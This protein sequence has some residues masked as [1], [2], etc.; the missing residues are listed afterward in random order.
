MEQIGERIRTLRES[1]G[2]SQKEL[3]AR[4]VEISASYL[5][6]VENV[7]IKQP[8]AV[9]LRV[10]AKALEVTF[11]DLIKN[12][13][14]AVAATEEDRKTSHVWCVNRNCPKAEVDSEVANQPSDDPNVARVLVEIMDTSYI[15]QWQEDGCW[16]GIKRYPSF[17]AYNQVGEKNT[18]CPACGSPL[19]DKCP[20]CKRQI[21]SGDQ[22]FCMGCGTDIWRSWRKIM[23]N[24]DEQVRRENQAYIKGRADH[25]LLDSST[26]GLPRC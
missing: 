6:N 24:P 17:P 23:Q 15:E 9:K 12:T 13:D 2:L 18:F 1:K 25:L 19:W 22:C 16:K 4:A 5:A 7:G 14:A 10:I 11:E 8:S 3:T 21:E 20:Q 26:D